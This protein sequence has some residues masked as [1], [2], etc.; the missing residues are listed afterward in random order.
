MDLLKEQDFS[1][2]LGYVGQKETDRIVDVFN[3]MMEQLKNER[4]HVREQNHFLDLLIQAS[5]M[6][7]LILDFDGRILSANPAVCR[8]LHLANEKDLVGQ[9][10]ALCAEPLLEEIRDIPLDASRSIRLSDA[11]IYKCSH[12]FFMDRGLRHEFY[13]IEV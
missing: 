2:R 7:V 13:L 6:G 12:S 4:L 5:P 9:Q 1:S 3:R 10:L 8:L 11:N